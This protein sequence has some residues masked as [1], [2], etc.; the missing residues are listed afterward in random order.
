[1][2]FV[3][4]LVTHDNDGQPIP[5]AVL[6][7]ILREAEARFGGYTLGNP[8]SGSWIEG[9]IRYAETSCRLEV[10][11]AA[12][13]IAEAREFVIWSGKE[14]HQLAMFF[15]IRDGGEIIDI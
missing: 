13:R 4:R 8:E 7:C 3:T 11:I 2:I 10:V 15:E 6:N 12:G 9:G 5:A 1:M 14:L